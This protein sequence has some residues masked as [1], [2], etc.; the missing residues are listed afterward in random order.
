MY[1]PPALTLHAVVLLIREYVGQLRVAGSQP[2]FPVTRLDSIYY[3]RM[4]CLVKYHLHRGKLIWKQISKEMCVRA[5]NCLS[6][7]TLRAE[8]KNGN[9]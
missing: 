8:W 9:L 1:F 7:T 5:Q 6:W 4:Y 3:I 2:A